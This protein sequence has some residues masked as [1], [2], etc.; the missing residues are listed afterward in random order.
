MRNPEDEMVA[1]AKALE[2]IV[3][4][5]AQLVG[6]RAKGEFILACLEKYDWLHKYLRTAYDPR[7]AYDGAFVAAIPHGLLNKI[8]ERGGI[9]PLPPT[10]PGVAGPAIGEF[11]MQVSSLTNKL[12]GGY[13]C[14]NGW[15][16]GPT[17]QRIANFT[18]YKGAALATFIQA[19]RRAGLRVNT[20][21]VD[22]IPF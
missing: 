18:V 16:D 14:G 1:Q 6:N 19:V 15:I 12:P 13:V 11:T 2:A 9:N 7:R 8:F 5:L 10:P 4:A 22:D 3:T 21:V 20:D 17:T